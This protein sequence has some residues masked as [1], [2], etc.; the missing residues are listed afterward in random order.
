VVSA[1]GLNEWALPSA[2]TRSLRPT[3]AR[4]SSTDEGRST[5][6]AEKTTLPAQFVLTR[7]GY[8]RLVA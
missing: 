3:R 6:R 4:N 5:D 8:G 1:I 7:S 2:R